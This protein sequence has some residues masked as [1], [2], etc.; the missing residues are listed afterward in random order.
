MG[1]NGS[2]DAERP[3]SFNEA[4]DLD[5]LPKKTRPAYTTWYRWW[6]KG[7]KGI[8]LQTLVVGGRRYTTRR[9]VE[10]WITAVTNAANGNSSPMRTPK[11]RLREIERAESE[12]NGQK[13]QGREG[14]R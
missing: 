14:A 3:I 4:A 6:K 8:C 12:I 5:L 2:S 1:G 13:K 9:F 11:Q 7:V 10:E